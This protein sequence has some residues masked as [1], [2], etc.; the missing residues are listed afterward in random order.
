MGRGQSGA[1]E[2]ETE[3][4]AGGFESVFQVVLARLEKHWRQ[5]ESQQNS[6]LCLP[7]CVDRKEYSQREPESRDGKKPL[8]MYVCSLGDYVET[9]SPQ[10][11]HQLLFQL[12]L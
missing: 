11:C 3:M 12:R 2:D 7:C 10:S 6:P 1:K 8:H 9:V 5:G 4:K